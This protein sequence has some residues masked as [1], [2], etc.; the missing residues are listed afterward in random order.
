[1]RPR[2]YCVDAVVTAWAWPAILGRME[3]GYVA[4][5]DCESTAAAAASPC[6]RVCLPAALT[7]GYCGCPLF[8]GPCWP[9]LGGRARTEVTA[10]DEGGPRRKL[11]MP[12]RLG[13]M[14]GK[15]TQ[16]STT[17]F[18][19]AYVRTCNCAGACRL[20]TNSAPPHRDWTHGLVPLS[21]SVGERWPLKPRVRMKRH[22]SRRRA[23]CCVTAPQRWSAHWTCGVCNASGTTGVAQTPTIIDGTCRRRRRS[24]SSRPPI[25]PRAPDSA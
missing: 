12:S 3:A 16:H 9:L 6:Q 1:M 23:G 5:Q 14:R 18:L 10:D 24:V 22:A 13:V 25:V 17:C 2:T 19:R 4:R 11:T 20:V 15:P 8:A 21:P 7:C